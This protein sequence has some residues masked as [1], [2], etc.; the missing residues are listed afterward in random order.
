MARAGSTP[1]Q[2]PA[3]S[4]GSPSRLRASELPHSM[5]VLAARSDA[6]RAACCGYGAWIFFCF[7]LPALPAANLCRAAGAW[8]TYVEASSKSVRDV[9]G[10]KCQACPRLYVV[11]R[12]PRWVRRGRLVVARR[13]GA[14]P[15]KLGSAREIRSRSGHL[16]RPFHGLP[17]LVGDCVFGEMKVAREFGD[18]RPVSRLLC[19]DQLIDRARRS[20]I[21]Q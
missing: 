21:A 3:A 15:A 18:A 5:G 2:A 9:P 11:S 4:G 8:T 17:V 19:E 14:V 20:C 13:D 10:P 16:A 6:L 7:G 12:V 1:G